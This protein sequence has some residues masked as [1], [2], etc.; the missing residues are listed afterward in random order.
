MV[1]LM[2]CNVSPVFLT[3]FLLA[4]PNGGYNGLALVMCFCRA[5]NKTNSQIRMSLG[6]CATGAGERVVDL[7]ISLENI[8]ACASPCNPHVPNNRIIYVIM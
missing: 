6:Q 1:S 3:D 8:W 5:I 2:A 4:D 7:T